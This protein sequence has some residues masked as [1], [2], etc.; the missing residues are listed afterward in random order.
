MA[1]RHPTLR[2]ETVKS[3][4]RPSTISLRQAAGIGAAL[5]AL[6]GCVVGPRYTVPA[7]TTEPLP[8]KY[9]ETPAQ[10]RGAVGWKVADPKDGTARGEWWKIFHDPQLNE[11]EAQLNL[12]NQ[13]T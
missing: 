3:G 13:N 2:D 12:N 11:L 1:S 4:R 5:C 7:P 10:P 6:T 8:A 9:K